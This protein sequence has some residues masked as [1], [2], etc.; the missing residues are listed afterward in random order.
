[1]VTTREFVERLNRRLHRL[2]TVAEAALPRDQFRA[3]RKVAL[4]EFGHM[5]LQSELR[6]L[7]RIEHDTKARNGMGRLDTG[8]ERRLP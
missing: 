5:G 8:T 2:L 4:D 7:E 1:M 3:F 6:E